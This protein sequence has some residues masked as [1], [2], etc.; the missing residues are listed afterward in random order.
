MENNS[1]FIFEPDIFFERP[2]QTDIS[3]SS[4]HLPGKKES[5]LQYITQGYIK[6]LETCIDI[7]CHQGI[8][9][10]KKEKRSDIR[11]FYKYYTAVH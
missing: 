4:I 2:T 11:G 5:H 10:R 1:T 3:S 8:S 7:I 6:K 9:E